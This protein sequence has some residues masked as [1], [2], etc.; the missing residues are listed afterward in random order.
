MYIAIDLKSFYASVECVA[1]G[2]DPLDT[3]LVVADLSR[4]EK[5]ICL[6]VTPSLK[7]FGISGR[8]R[9]FEVVQ[10]VGEVNSLRKSRLRGK[11]F[12]GESH[13]LSK[14]K[15]RPDK[16]L[17][18]IVAPPRMAEYMRVSTRIY[19]I[20]LRYIAPED[21]HVYSVDE[22]FIDASRYLRTYRMTARELADKLIREVLSETG[23]T[24]TAGIGTNL[25][26]C[27]IAMDIVAKKMEPDEHGV[28]IAELDE[29]SYR[30]QLWSH[31]P[32]TDFW[33]IGGGY[34]R[35]LARYGMFTMGD[36]ARMSLVNES[37][38]YKLFGVNAELLIDHA[39]GYEPCTMREI[40]SYR[41]RSKSLSLGQVLSTPYDFEKA[42]LIIREMADLLT[43]DLVKKGLL[44]DQVVLTVGYDIENISDSR[45]RA[46]YHG[47]IKTDHY[48]RQMPKQA[49]GSE[50]IGCFCSSTRKITEAVTRLFERIVNP[51]LLVRRMY[52]AANHT[53]P[54]RELDPSQKS[55]QL[56]LFD[57][58]EP[59]QNAFEAREKRI[60]QAILSLRTRYG[61]NAVLKGMN[62][63][64][65]ATT[66]ERNRQIGGHLA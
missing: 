14:L 50:N 7:S 29:Q 38:L 55:E 35:S 17:G 37:L 15:A 45:R 58:S 56:S 9:L 26:L 21:I 10:R 57:L 30:E 39:W 33:R 4:T 34:S 63:R 54:E 43:L 47:E 3:N 42:R 46:L 11:D 22:V 66:R 18:Y 60:Q 62:F 13:F 5:T 6:A 59:A 36:V 51:D 2:L 1:R 20:Y 44:T 23:I 64:E 48:G 49:H 16:K 28:R 31:T 19:G 27:K 24:A 52:I 12:S 8:A 25:Y 65:G 61:K 40:K 41:P 53:V 32:I